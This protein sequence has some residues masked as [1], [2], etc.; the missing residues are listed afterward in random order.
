LSV[1]LFFPF[2]VQSIIELN[3]AEL[4]DH[5]AVPLGSA[6]DVAVVKTSTRVEFKRFL[7]LLLLSIRFF[8]PLCNAEWLGFPHWLCHQTLDTLEGFN[9]EAGMRE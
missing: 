7:R 2:V 5:V 4:H 3:L 8:M 9:R 1:L 6:L